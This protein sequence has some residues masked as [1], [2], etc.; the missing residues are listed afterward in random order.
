LETAIFDL[1]RLDGDALDD[2]AGFYAEEGY[3][4]LGGL[5]ESLTQRYLPVLARTAGLSQSELEAMLDPKSPEPML[6]E[7]LRKKFSRVPTQE[8]L[9]GDLI[10]SLRPLLARLLGPMVHV[11]RDFHAQ[12]KC[13]V[14]GRVGYGG[15]DSQASFLEVHGAYQ[16]HQDF[17]GASL[18]TS[19]AALILW[20]GLNDCPDWPIRFYPRSHRLGL[21]CRRFVPVDH[22]GLPQIGRPMESH[23]RPGT[24]IVFNSLL[25]HGTGEGGALRRVSCDIRFFP[26]CPWLQSE[27]RPLVDSPMA[28]LEDRLERETAPTLR[29]PLLVNL[30][31]AGRMGDNVQAPPHSI[32]N[33]ANYLNEVLNGDPGRAPGHIERFA[34]AEIG[35]EPPAAYVEQ[36]HGR[37]MQA[38]TLERIWESLDP[39]ETGH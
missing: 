13:G 27:P 5:Q 24:G 11:S 10:R 12:F 8:C 39:A 17:T 30:A 31:L 34:N 4:I 38:A 2:L 15:Y 16:L 1:R 9:A 22:E 19:P 32:L 35:M 3:C 33:W 20:V 14:T 29:A 26:S 25:L 21:L 28:F 7:D 6:P 37:P 18:P 36:F 23:A